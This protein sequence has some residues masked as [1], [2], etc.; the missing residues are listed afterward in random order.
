MKIF[1]LALSAA[2][3]VFSIPSNAKEIRLHCRTNEQKQLLT[4]VVLDD[5]KRR[6][7]TQG[8]DGELKE[9]SLR[10]LTPQQLS[11]AVDTLID[12]RKYDP[13]FYLEMNST[14]TINR[15]D[16]YMESTIEGRGTPDAPFQKNYET[17]S[18][19]VTDNKLVF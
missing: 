17:G 2:L 5:V 14:Y 15:I 11:F 7:W 19:I 4:V 13:P 12:G 16:G 9:R 18:C 6:V 8:T 3:I 1:H 10:K